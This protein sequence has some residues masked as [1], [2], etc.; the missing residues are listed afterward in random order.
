MWRHVETAV[1]VPHRGLVKSPCCSP[2][3]A[4]AVSLA[5]CANVPSR[6]FLTMVFYSSQGSIDICGKG[7]I[8]LWDMEQ[9]YS[10][11]ACGV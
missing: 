3:K 11:L 9:P 7:S 10:A 4:L 6:D 1:E 5:T 2:V 8:G